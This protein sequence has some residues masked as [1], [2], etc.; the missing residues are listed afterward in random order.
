MR[1]EKFDIDELISDSI[2]N[3]CD[4]EDNVSYLWPDM[5]WADV[6]EEERDEI[7]SR[8]AYCDDCG[9]MDF[10]GNM[11]W[12]DSPRGTYCDGCLEG[13][14]EDEDFENYD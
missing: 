7:E 8:T 6:T 11:E 9:R 3:E 1:H 4:L 14:A 13:Y 2:S 12:R 5:T 10:K